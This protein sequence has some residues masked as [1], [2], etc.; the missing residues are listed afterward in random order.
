MARKHLAVSAASALGLLLLGACAGGPEGGGAPQQPT[1]VPD[2]ARVQQAT[3][4]SG[5]TAA[6]VDGVGEVVTDQAGFTLYRFDK[7]TAKPP[8]SNCNG[9]CATQWPPVLSE[10]S[11][12]LKGI[13]NTAVGKVK[14]DDG[15]EQVTIGGWPVYRFAKDA[16]PGE[17]K[18]QS[19]GGTWYAVTAKGGK[20]GQAAA[21]PA[22]AAPAAGAKLVA[23]QA[24]GVGPILTDQNGMSLYLF[25]KDSKKPSK[26]TC[27]GDCAK[28]WPPMMSEGDVQLEGVDPKL[29]GKVKRDD[30]GEQVTVG[31]W[32][33]Y[34]FAKDTKPGEA[35]G[36][37]VGGTWFAIEPNGCKSQAA[38]QQQ[39]ANPAPS[40]APNSA[41][42]TAPSSSTG[43]GGGGY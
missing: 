13:E 18:G 26:A 1:A 42:S 41:P 36:H 19:V 17:A 31:G 30:G 9:D 21:A 2:V 20:A 3:G 33:V 5:L 8:K 6:Q 29:V 22:P 4:A 24:E 7:D 15:S 14:R 23:G 35:K 43:S 37:G 40:S 34:R 10:G 38:P 25:A 12:E 11:M 32:P 28:Q 16:K 39:P 27:D